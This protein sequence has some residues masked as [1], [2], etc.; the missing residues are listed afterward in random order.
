MD[1]IRCAD[2][3]QVIPQEV[4]TCPE[5]GS[6]TPHGAEAAARRRANHLW[7]VAFVF[8][9]AV[10]LLVLG[11]VSFPLVVGTVIV[12]GGLVIVSLPFIAIHVHHRHHT[13]HHR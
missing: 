8:L 6:R 3:H 12:L 2:C 13:H 10:P 4:D 11:G 1:Q 5:C 7:Y 9:L